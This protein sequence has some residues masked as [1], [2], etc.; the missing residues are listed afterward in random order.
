MA[1]KTKLVA[2][3]SSDVALE[4]QMGDFSAQEAPISGSKTIRICFR[5]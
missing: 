5:H 4:V 1:P 2:S 3:S